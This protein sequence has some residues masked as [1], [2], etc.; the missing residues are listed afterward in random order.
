MIKDRVKY[1][2]TGGWGWARWVKGLA[3][4]QYVRTRFSPARGAADY[5][6]LYAALKKR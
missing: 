3:L 2:S 5:A 6:E 4:S 1:K